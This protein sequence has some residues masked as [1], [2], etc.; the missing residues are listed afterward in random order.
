MLQANAISYKCYPR[1]DNSEIR[2]GRVMVHKQGIFLYHL[3]SIYNMSFLLS[4]KVLKRSFGQEG[5]TLGQGWD[6]KPQL[7]CHHPFYG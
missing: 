7:P 3:L 6:S 5:A 4:L 2:D 1:G